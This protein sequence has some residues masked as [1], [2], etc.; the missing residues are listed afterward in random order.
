MSGSVGVVT[1]RVPGK[2]QFGEQFLDSVKQFREIIDGGVPD[3]IC[4]YIIVV[5]NLAS[6]IRLASSGEICSS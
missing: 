4:V 1:R 3:G 2:V 6:G 5:M